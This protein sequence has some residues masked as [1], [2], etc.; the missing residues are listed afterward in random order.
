M[1][2]TYQQAKRIRKSSLTGLIA[3]QL[4]YERKIGTAVKK[5]I[6]L[7]TRGTIMGLTQ[8]FDPLNIA[9]ILTFGSSLGPAILGHLTK[10]DARDIQYFTGRLKPIRESKGRVEKIGRGGDMGDVTSS[11]VLQQIYAHLLKTRDENKQRA[12]IQMNYEEEYKIE[13][14]RRHKELLEVLSG[15][16]GKTI[17]VTKITKTEG[18]VVGGFLDKIRDMIGG[19][20]NGLKT[21]VETLFQNFAKWVTKSLEV[22]TKS[23]STLVRLA[24]AP[25]RLL[26][27]N[28]IVLGALAALA[29]AYAI[30]GFRESETGLK[31]NIA[32]L[33]RY[34]PQK[35]YELDREIRLFGENSPK[36]APKR[37]ALQKLMDERKGYQQKLDDLGSAESK[38]KETTSVFDK[39]KSMFTG[40][41]DKMFEKT[42]FKVDMPNLSFPSLESP[43]PAPER[44]QPTPISEMTKDRA[45]TARA[46]FAKVD[47]R[48][49]IV[50]GEMDT[51]GNMLNRVTNENIQ[52]KLETKTAPPEPVVNNTN[53]NKTSETTTIKKNLPNVRNSEATFQR[54]IFDSTRVV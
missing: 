45:Q 39:F 11:P 34:I 14:E 23:L 27:G 47:P 5:A 50:T 6:S 42:D 15:L 19:A 44:V 17:T 20:V 54:M 21:M 16:S 7:K 33:D 40:D 22:L 8:K 18:N 26:L 30:K 2:I 41:Y 43:A 36:V 52:N 13:S 53:I 1:T 12:Q 10:R 48:L 32:R 46:D 4:Q 51:K 37:E 3:D 35:Q 28:P 29:G 9:K 38:E 24:V 31:T 25:L 49:K